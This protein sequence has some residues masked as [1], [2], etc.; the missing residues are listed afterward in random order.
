MMPRI[1]PQKLIDRGYVKVSDTLDGLAEKCG[2]DPQGLVAEVDK[3]NQ[4]AAKG[5]DL[6]FKRGDSP[7][8]RYYSDPSVKPNPCLRPL[9]SSPFYAVA[10]WPGDI[11]T[12]GGLKTNA[13]AR[14]LREDNS[15]IDGLYAT[16][17]CSA[18]VMGNT[19]AGAGATIGAA[20][21]FGYISALHVST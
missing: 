20:M 4:Y 19:Y 18:S 11:G 2:I 1:T 9:D 12:K 8:D 5:N 16:G 10:L 15:V 14:V 17:N 21:V 7:I 3:F 6:D 13:Y